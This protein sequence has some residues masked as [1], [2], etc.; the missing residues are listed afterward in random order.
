MNATI[1]EAME[2]ILYAI[3]FPWKNIPRFIIAKLQRGRKI[4][5]NATLGC[6]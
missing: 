4:V 3:P 2:D 1:N 6:L 5:T